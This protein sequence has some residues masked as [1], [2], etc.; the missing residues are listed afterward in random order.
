M[1]IIILLSWHLARWIAKLKVGRFIKFST[2]KVTRKFC[3]NMTFI[4][5][6]DIEVK[7]Q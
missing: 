7:S 1:L 5:D 3:A 2:L 6:I 4:E